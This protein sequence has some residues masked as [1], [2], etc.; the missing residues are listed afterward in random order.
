MAHM[1][2]HIYQRIAKYDDANAANVKGVA[3][4]R[5]YTAIA[6][7]QGFY[8]MYMSHNSHFLAWT[9]MV[10]GRSAE[11][12]KASRDAAAQIDP[13]MARAMVGTDFF[14]AEPMFVMA[15]FGRWKE[16]LQVPVTPEGLPYMRGIRH[17]IR[18]LAYAGTQQFDA[19]ATALDSLTAIRDATPDDAMEGFNSAKALLTI[20][21]HVLTGETALA[22]GQKDEAVKHLEEAV[23]GEDATRYD[24]SPDWIYPTRHY[25]GRALLA[26]GRAAD[27]ETVYREDL[28]RNPENGWSLFGLTQSLKSQ[29]K[30]T[31]AAATDTKFRKAWTHADVKLTASAF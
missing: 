23:K 9:Y 20:A 27:A 30:T 10:Q 16:A 12:L 6:R 31:E 26:D 13:A 8:H 7:P 14:I 4:D 28:R 25:L 29:G 18:G 1:P 2:A 19:A 15:R 3:A 11:A 17:Y 24:E 22:R 21:V 5:A